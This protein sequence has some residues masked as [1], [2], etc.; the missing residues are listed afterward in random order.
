M[1][2]K[3]LVTRR[4]FSTKIGR[5]TEGHR[6]DTGYLGFVAVTFGLLLALH[7]IAA[8]D[9]LSVTDSTPVPST[10]SS[11]TLKG[12]CPIKQC[13]GQSCS[14]F[15]RLYRTEVVNTCQYPVKIEVAAGT[16][17]SSGQYKLG[18]GQHG[19]YACQEARDGC[20]G[21]KVSL[22]SEET[23]STSQDT[24]NPPKNQAASAADLDAAKK[25]ADAARAK[26]I[27]AEKDQAAQRSAQQDEKN[28]LKESAL[29]LPQFCEGM[30][31]MCQERVA[32]VTT[33]QTRS[34]CKAYCTNLQIENCNP[35]SEI[36]DGARACNAGIESDQKEAARQKREQ[37]A[38]AAAQ[39]ARDNYIPPGW[40]SC[41]CPA[42]HMHLIGQGR[43]KLVNGVLYHPRDV[44]PCGGG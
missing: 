15:D 44:G 3:G 26:A 36:Q 20:K 24:H 9:C 27:Q 39:R 28:K 43:A 23:E 17:W 10:E 37:E 4:S 8:A 18:K 30:I 19:Q 34:Q 41:S 31:Q 6:R 7:T 5:E 25:R 29:K 35:S 21:V 11:E 16:N 40:A 2:V 42:D 38:A 12:Q 13:Y 33:D 14:C 1:G 22:I 32:S